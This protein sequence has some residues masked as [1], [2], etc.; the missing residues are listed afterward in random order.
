M[1]KDK[2]EIS[3]WEDYEVPAV[4]EKG[5]TKVVVPAH[6]RERKIGIIGSDTLT[7]QNRAIAPTL[8]NNINGT[9]TLTFQMY[10]SYIDNETGENVINP[11]I[12]LLVNERKI[13]VYWKKRWYDMVIKSVV[14]SSDK[15]TITYTCKD[16]FINE[17]SKN[18]FNLEFDGEL[19]NNTG[20]I[21]ELA[22]AILEGTDWQLAEDGVILNQTLEEPVYE[23]AVSLPFQGTGV[24]GN[25]TGSL[26][27]GTKILVFYSCVANREPFCQFWYDESGNYKAETT[28]QLALNGACYG[29]EGVKWDEITDSTYGTQ[30]LVASTNDNDE[31]F[32]INLTNGVS[33]NF[34]AERLVRKQKTVV[35]PKLDRTVNIYKKGD[36]QYY[37]YS[38]V[39]YKSPTV[40]N[41][42]VASN[43]NF[44]ADS[45]GW[46]G[47]STRSV[48]Y[49]DWTA[50]TSIGSGY[51]ATSHL[52]L[53]KGVYYLN[54]GVKNNTSYIPNG[55]QIGDKWVLRY[56]VRADDGKE[57]NAPTG[58]YVEKKI[59]AYIGYYTETSSDPIVYT[60]KD[61]GYFEEVADSRKKDGDWTEATYLCVKGITKSEISKATCFNFLFKNESTAPVWIEEIE[62][63]PYVEGIVYEEVTSGVNNSNVANYYILEN[64]VY[65]KVDSS[66]SY[67]SGTKYYAKST[68]RINPG[69]MDMQSIAQ[70]YY[71]YYDP[72]QSYSGAD[73]LLYTYI[74]TEKSNSFAPYYGS[75]ANDYEKVRTITG[76]ESNRFNLIQNLCETFECWASFETAHNEETGEI[77][78]DEKG[79]P[80]KTVSFRGEIGERT[81]LGF[82]YGIDLKTIQ[83]TVNSDQIVTK[84]IV[85]PNSNE[86][87]ENG[88]CTIARAQ[89]NY[90][91]EA[92]VL[93]FGYYIAQGML[94]SGQ[95]SKDLYQT[96]P[97]SISYY[98]SLNQYNTEYD[99]NAE[100]LAAKNT[101]LTKQKAFL[102]TYSEYV[103]SAAEQLSTLESRIMSL[104]SKS[105]LDEALAYAQ[106]NSDYTSLNT[107]V[108]TRFDT[109]KNRD[110]MSA[111]V[112]KLEQ[113]IA[114]IESEI[115]QL[116]ERQKELKKAIDDKHTEFWNKYSAYIQEGVWTSE[117][118]VDDELYYLDACSVAYTSARPQTTYSISVLRLSALEEFS[119]KV[120][121][122]GDICYIQDTDFFGYHY[123]DNILTPYKEEIFVSEITS[124]FD[125]PDKDTFKVQNYKT[126]FEDLFQ[127]I[128]A[129]TQSLQYASGS[130]AKAAALV[131][132]TGNLTFTT[133]QNAFA[134][135]ENLVQ[136]SQNETITQDSTGITLVNASNPN[137][138]VKLTSAGLFL[139]QD[140]GVSWKAGVEGN[141]VSTSTL[142][143]GNINTNLITVMN[144]D[145]E[146]YRWDENGISAYWFDESTGSLHLN[147]FIR[148]DQF[149]LY[150]ASGVGYPDGFKTKIFTKEN[151]IWENE[152]TRFALTWKG[153]LLRNT[154]GTG[155]IEI[156]STRNAIVV[157]QGDTE[158]VLLGAFDSNGDKYGLRFKNTKGDVT[159]ETDDGGNL[160]LR[161]ELSIGTSDGTHSA[162][163]TLGDKKVIVAGDNTGDNFILYE[164]GTIVAKRITLDG[165]TIGGLSVAELPNTLG[166]RIKEDSGDTFKK[167]NGEVKP[168]SLSFSVDTSIEGEKDYQWQISSDMS[169]WSIKG[170]SET[171]TLKY[172]D[173]AEVFSS[174][175][176]YLKVVVAVSGKNYEDVISLKFVSDGEKGADGAA[177]ANGTS[178]YT[179]IRYADNA[180]GS[181]MSTSPEGKAY[182][183]ICTKTE[184]SEPS[185][186]DY[187]W[188][189]F[190]GDD[191][192]P[193]ADGKDGAPGKDAPEVLA[194]YSED[195][196]TNWHTTYE[197]T[198]KYI[199]LSYNGGTDWDTVP[200]IKIVGEN[201]VN[202]YTY[203]RYADK[204]DGSDM[205]TSPEG[206]SYIGICV[207][208]NPSDATNYESYEWSKFVGEDAPTVKAQYSED[209]ENWHENFNEETDLYIQLSY[210][211]GITWG[212]TIKIVG[213]DGAPGAD[214]KDGKD[215]NQ[216]LIVTN[217]E[218]LLR[219][220]SSANESSVSYIFSPSILSIQLRDGPNSGKYS[221][222]GQI[223]EFDEGVTY[224]VKGAD[225]YTVYTGE[226]KKGEY[227]QKSP[228][229]F[230]DI[231]KYSVDIS[232][233]GF[234]LVE[235]LGE[236]LNYYINNLPSDS[237]GAKISSIAYYFHVQKL[238]D[239]RDT[240]IGSGDNYNEKWR[241]FFNSLN[242][243]NSSLA[244]KI[245]TLMKTADGDEESSRLISVKTGVNSDLARLSLEAN[246]IYAAIQDA[247]F[248]FNSLG[249]KITNGNFEIVKT[250][251]DDEGNKT[252]V[253]GLYYNNTDG[254][255]SINGPIISGGTITGVNGSF[256]G[257]VTATSGSIGGFTIANNAI[258]SNDGELKLFASVKA[259]EENGIL[260]QESKIEV[261]NI[262]LGT[263]ATVSDYI[264]LGNLY[265]YNPVKH[266]GEAI[267]AFDKNGDAAFVLK[268]NGIITV[269]GESVIQSKQIP[270]TDEYYWKLSPEMAMFQNGSFSGTVTA[271]T[272]NAST[273][274]TQVFKAQ[275]IQ[276]MG[277]S[278]I[279]RPSTRDIS[280]AAAEDTNTYTVTINDKEF[281]NVANFIEN[282]AIMLQ[283]SGT[284][285]TGTFRV[286]GYVSSIVMTA[287]QKI[288]SITVVMDKKIDLSA[289]VDALI[290]LGQ[291]ATNN[292]IAIN[293][294]KST[295]GSNFL[296]PHALSMTELSRGDNGW[297]T[298]E[299]LVLGDLDWIEKLKGKGLG[300]GLYS[301]NV[302]LMG[303]LITTDKTG[304][305]VAGINSNSA[306]SPMKDENAANNDRFDGNGHTKNDRVLMWAGAEDDTTASILNAPFLVT[307][308]GF[309]YA[310]KGVFSNGIIS[311]ST[312]S[313]STIKSAIIDGSGEKGEPSL[314]IY[315]TETDN[316]TGVQFRKWTNQNTGEFADTLAIGHNG[317][318]LGTYEKGITPFISLETTN[319]DSDS[320]REISF[321]GRRYSTDCLKIEDGIIEYVG[322]ATTID[323]TTEKTSDAVAKIAFS[324]K[325]IKVFNNLLIENAKIELKSL[326]QLDETIRFGKETENRMEYKRDEKEG[327]SLYVFSK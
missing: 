146:Q 269:Q 124:Y 202:S 168:S 41:N 227:Y 203:V 185:A 279:F 234:S 266:G 246:G 239:D 300:Y 141:G 25:K 271:S 243:S 223:T 317:F 81:G 140:G 200:V 316:N 236:S 97:G 302:Y 274:I 122:L 308:E 174:A 270:G 181:N 33:E 314:I 254:S 289:T 284:G 27:A 249:L 26:S 240:L 305:T 144:E 296:S 261:K 47:G 179:Y 44:S 163:G 250:L 64:S 280:I 21:N 276:A 229:T 143:S 57:S 13:K 40:V 121:H 313:A 177:G 56:K 30:Y 69:E 55:F 128:T 215:S 36:K 51:K 257:E 225:G 1:I 152:A 85:K 327:Y 194:Q 310:N 161:N 219:F 72:E 321:K 230:F 138:V 244:F 50:A 264:R 184:P 135:N 147:K 70:I 224:Y 210:D 288:K 197:A 24:N 153:F 156:D 79:L 268:D 232:L 123:V 162:I 231:T 115:V 171:I 304:G 108:Q 117:D 309:V 74:G 198:D 76:K 136:S 88:F 322:T 65:Q 258:Y 218:E 89:D 58:E 285:S 102:T 98:Y 59:S 62:F 326:A 3:V 311:N 92:F 84:T 125:T 292:I 182:I 297:I 307:K 15:H 8:V 167:T 61:D 104:A 188:S 195:G 228:E 148:F 312:I 82:I 83:R 134:R 22:A 214:G 139:S 298:K 301:D 206:K 287:D 238:Y 172:S 129:T 107:A 131:D 7:T 320:K 137:Q 133:L 90:S 180:N 160:W 113:S 111:L 11:W 23:V 109:I 263:G 155:K 142:T 159:L 86:F 211:N 252:Q 151:Q 68:R 17:L 77:S 127:R 273:I 73:D 87:A 275:Q 145:K 35:D 63:F 191:G 220:S 221:S 315:D 262:V 29:I 95:V 323:T 120:F 6:F 281:Q 169:S 245:G 175:I 253:Q 110:N 237:E 54:R 291:A 9:S 119:S 12:S 20:T 205:S 325:Q 103:N 255:L 295:G 178:S 201:G 272:I 213:D 10:Y 101:E 286:Q 71:K 149:G 318:Y 324:K 80:C 118:Y 306:I 267:V 183:G 16:A 116:E 241:D 150:G 189:K 43:K 5:T 158:R 303:S 2:Y 186:A 256:S 132:T 204:E 242:N 96:T 39:E 187:E 106:E 166:V 216:Y 290:Y 199:R 293:S 75:G 173:I 31:L 235:N 259:D 192:K 46:S 126:Q 299:R 53:E 319:S 212:E 164:D 283:L 60:P 99:A 154:L 91:K 248:E 233:N 222:V 93:D 112:T 18:G 4:Y 170:S 100:V 32:K 176:C 78:Y 34:R 130:Y 278:F 226:F 265:L 277:G 247:G 208:D 190:V 193:G 19:Q 209:G 67:D 28:N 282:D 165:G 207:T 217:Q 37:G 94:S 38:E 42:I 48:L 45:V 196:S 49:P 294:E 14:E 251:T 157:S 105:T 114:Q 260:A 66:A 52:Q